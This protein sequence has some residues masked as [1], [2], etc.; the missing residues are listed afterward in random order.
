[1]ILLSNW[2]RHCLA[3]AGV[4][5]SLNLGA[6]NCPQDALTARYW[7]YRE[8][9]NR[10]FISTD[11]NNNGCIGDGLGQSATDPCSCTAEGLSLPATSINMSPGGAGGISDRHIS[12][13][14]LFPNGE[15][16]FF[17]DPDCGGDFSWAP[18]NPNA[19][20]PP[21]YKFNYLEMGS[22][23]PTQLGW[24]LVMLATEYE[25]LG[26]NGQ[27]EEQQRV[28]EDIFLALQAIRRL[29]IRAQCLAKDRYDAINSAGGDIEL[30][31][32]VYRLK[33]GTTGMNGEEVKVNFD[34]PCD[35]CTFTPRT[36][37]YGGFLIRED[38]TQALEDRLHDASEDRY[39][40]DLISS[41]YALSEPSNCTKTEV[42]R[43]CYIVHRQGFMS[44]DQIISLFT[45]L[46]FVKRYIPS[47]ANVRTCDGR[48]FNVM[49]IAKNIS[50]GITSNLD[51]SKKGHRLA[52]PGSG[53]CCNKEVFLSF[54]EG[55]VF[56]FTMFGIEKACNYITGRTA[57]ITKKDASLW[58]SLAYQSY[59]PNV[60]KS[61]SNSN[62][63]LTLG[64]LGKDIGN[65]TN[66]NNLAQLRN[67]QL[68]PLMNNLLY[69]SSP[70]FSG[71]KS[72][73]ETL[74]CLAPC[75]G[76]CS[77]V[78]SD[79]FA[80]A[81]W[82][83]FSCPNMPGWV[84]QRWDGA[85]D[86]IDG[87][88]VSASRLFNGLDYMVLH[89]IYLLNYEPDAPF[90]NPT[91]PEA[92]AL[93]YD[94]SNYVG[95]SFIE[96]PDALCVG[97]T[98]RY[99]A[100][101]TL[102]VL[103]NATNFTWSSSSNLVLGAAIPTTIN[104]VSTEQIDATLM[105]SQP[106]SHIRARFQQIRVMPQF[107]RGIVV[108]GP[109]FTEQCHFDYQKP[110]LGELLNYTVDPKISCSWAEASAVGPYLDYVTFSWQITNLSSNQTVV[111]TGRKC[112][113]QD[114]ITGSSGVLRIVLTALNDNCDANQTTTIYVPYYGC[115][116]GIPKIDVMPN[117]AK[118]NIAI[119]IAGEP[120]SGGSNVSILIR[121]ID[122]VTPSKIT[123]IYGNG[124]TINVDDLP[125]G[126]Y[127]LQGTAAQW[128]QPSNTVFV[129]KR[130]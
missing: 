41:P 24:Y 89:N 65:N 69:P 4:F 55:G 16:N 52:F 58:A 104:S 29:D 10:H 92:G 105:N 103:A 45:G 80:T 61:E 93:G 14:P 34:S 96:G 84:G 75:S 126:I 39:N 5:V 109:P 66:Y 119:G 18:G 124:Q 68:Y 23:T 110:I 88:A 11:R 78:P 51:G 128:Q 117:P 127:L 35:P 60:P 79:P 129:I 15:N 85:G 106:N 8:R 122:A 63:F 73:L 26:K 123:T 53:D 47:N 120:F 54:N 118:D 107:D 27:V 62:F 2:F 99:R 121:S 83:D 59:H 22:E 108:T 98:G 71:D 125:D 44:Q 87:H 114:L 40:I 101:P 76:P 111:K 86:I 116:E 36:D 30:C 57:S 50:N 17:E 130:N 12:S 91:R 81:A 100:L 20:L 9:F 72:Y 1:M 97:Q 115:R 82:P 94:P 67:K 43:T 46:A 19:P 112:D 42:D 7:E 32:L 31:P 6:Q 102:P 113:F 28:L 70:N 48:L 77:M 33:E 25:L 37:G 49:D 13:P 95:S 38:A 64:M 21:N 56:D 74:M 3:V 90:Y